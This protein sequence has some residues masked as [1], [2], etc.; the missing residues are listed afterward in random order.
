M[1]RCFFT[2]LCCGSITVFMLT[3]CTHKKEKTAEEQRF[4]KSLTEAKIS[5]TDSVRYL[6]WNSSSCGGCRSYTAQLLA[7]K[8]TGNKAIKLIVPLDFAE[9]I[10][11]HS[12]ADIIVDSAGIFDKLY[13]GIDNVGLVNVYN[14]EV[15]SIR[16]YRADEMD[17]LKNDLEQ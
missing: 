16:N 3:S 6:V 12:T 7:K 1:I 9:D 10:P 13:F 15:W 11:E 4:E 17:S 2:A 14:G 5:D 8:L